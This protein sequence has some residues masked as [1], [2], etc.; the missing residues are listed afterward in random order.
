MWGWCSVYIEHVLVKEMGLVEE[1]HRVD[2]L[3]PDA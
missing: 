2:A 1:K 3:S